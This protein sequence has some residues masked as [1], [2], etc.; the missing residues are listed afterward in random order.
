MPKI[1]V[2]VPV[3][4]VEE[5]LPK[6][7]ASIVNQTFKDI[8]IICVNDGSTDNSLDI[9]RTYAE[10]DSRIKVI[11]QT[12][13]GLS[14]ARNTGIKAAQGKYLAFVDSDD[15]INLNT[16]EIV[17]RIIKQHP[18]AELIHFGTEIF[19]NAFMEKRR[20]D[21]K[22]YNNSYKGLK[23]VE[24]KIL[25]NLD[26]A[27]WNKIFKTEIV[28]KYDISFPKN[29][30][31]EDFNFCYKYYA[32]CNKIFFLKEKLYHYNRRTTSIM[33]ETFNF[34]SKT[35]D[36]LKIYN[37]IY[38]FYKQLNL[39]D[40]YNERLGYVFLNCFDFVVH[41]S[42]QKDL[43]YI[44]SM[45]Q[46]ILSDTCTNFK[47]PRIRA[48]L[49]DDTKKAIDKRSF[50]QK[51]FS[52]KNQG[53][54]KVTNICG[55]K[56]KTK[57]IVKL[58]PQPKVLVHLHLYYS[59]QIDYMLNKLKNINN[60]E[61]DLFVTVCNEDNKITNKL[62]AFK[63]DVKIIKV[64]NAGYDIW[65]FIQVLNKVELGNYNYI[66]KIHTKN[67]RKEK[68]GRCGKGFKWRNLLIDA[69]LKFKATEF[70]GLKVKNT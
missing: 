63:P 59:N 60:C 26:A 3:Y 44:M 51:I 14:A 25:F 39:A 55:L 68:A 62:K 13:Q 56:V 35:S 69:L 19:G 37:D 52:L 65:P 54:Y 27:V 31:Y 66:L 5:Y 28:K 12:N 1:S 29:L 36:H 43:K 6:C 2:I 24:D 7:L 9:L 46:Q 11:N 4:N 30:H 41:F 70:W 49:N 16:Y 33:G 47:H 57:R 15:Y 22:Y 50:L 34:N 45:A 8:E 20:G 21:Y 23:K 38:A 17:N 40:K 61:W 48:I 42:P 64:N 67:Y 58:T 18:Q 10:K 53:N 32:L